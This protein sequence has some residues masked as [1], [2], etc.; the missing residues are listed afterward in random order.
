MDQCE[1]TLKRQR[2]KLRGQR[3]DDKRREIGTRVIGM[4]HNRRPRAEL[5]AARRSRGARQLNQDYVTKPHAR[6]SRRLSK[7]P[8]SSSLAASHADNSA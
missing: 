4:H 8:K 7:I 1:T 5:L 6:Y 3:H 2:F